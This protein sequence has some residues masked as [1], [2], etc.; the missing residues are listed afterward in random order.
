MLLQQRW[1]PLWFGLLLVGVL[2]AAGIATAV[3]VGEK[4]PDF[5]LPSTLGGKVS[6]S[7][8]WGKKLVLLEFHVN[9]YGAT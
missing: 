6:L 1:R 2:A 7:Q 3:E 4:A 8:F 5:T 9:D